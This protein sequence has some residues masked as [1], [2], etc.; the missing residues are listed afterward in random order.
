MIRNLFINHV[1]SDGNITFETNVGAY[2]VRIYKR[3]IWIPVIVDDLLPVLRDDEWDRANQGFAGAHV[4]QGYAIWASLIEKAFAKYNGSYSKLER[5]FVHHA[6]EDL[7]GCETV[8]MSL[9]PASRG[10]GKR[11]LWDQLVRFCSFG[12]ILGAGTGAATVADKEIQ[13]MGIVFDA[14]YTIQ[15]ALAVDHHF[16]VKLRHPPG[17]HKSWKGDWSDDSIL[18]NHRYRHLLRIEEDDIFFMSF[19]DFCNVFKYLFVCKWFHPDRWTSKSYRGQWKRSIQLIKTAGQN[20][21]LILQDVVSLVEQDQS[22]PSEDVKQVKTATDARLEIQSNVDTAGGLP[23]KHNPA[24]VIENN[25]QYSLLIRKPTDIHIEVQ[26]TD[27]FG[28]ISDSIHPVSI[29]VAA[30]DNKHFPKR[31]MT[32]TKENIV[33]HVNPK[34]E[35]TVH[36]DARLSPGLYVVIVPTYIA[37]MIGHFSITL[38]ARKRVDFR[39][40]WPPE[41]ITKDSPPPQLPEQVLGEFSE[42]K[43]KNAK[44]TWLSYL[45]RSRSTKVIQADTNIDDYSKV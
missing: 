10:I 36:L 15:D 4:N 6:L 21:P 20:L 2:C 23:S 16:V 18:W 30:N 39:P 7:T 5:G 9:R 12:F 17:D 27:F 1:T 34:Q 3:G 11:A 24:C 33:A 28:H 43:K 32:L 8:C 37:G 35:R 29:L 31:L 42:S 38:H 14:A 41:W 44:K 40:L 22:N 25:P 26:Q 13:D 19:D 45:R